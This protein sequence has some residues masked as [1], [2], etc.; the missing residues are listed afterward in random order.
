[1]RL[2]RLLPAG[3]ALVLLIAILVFDGGSAYAQDVG[4]S[5]QNAT[6]AAERSDV[7]AGLVDVAV[8]NRA[9]IEAQLTAT[10]TRISD[11]SAQLSTVAA[12]LDR[13]E[14]Q[15]VFADA[16]M[17]SI[18]AE[19]E[20]QA[21]EAY[22]NALAIP[23][24]SFVNSDTVESALVAG[25]VVEEV[26]VSGRR[27]VEHLVAKR[28]ELETLQADYLNKQDEVADLK[29]QVDLE[30][31]KLAALYDQADAKV[32][33]AIREANA[34][35]V[36]YRSALSAVDSARAR[37][38]EQKRQDERT[39]TTA[40]APSSPTPTTTSPP[41][42]SSP[43]TSGGGSGGSWTGKPGVE[44]WRGA[45]SQYFPAHRVDEALQ[46]MQCESLGDPNAYN[47]YSGASGLYQFLPAT[48][49][50]TAPM[51]GFPNVSV[52][53]PVANIATAAWLANRYEQLGQNYWQP[54]SCR[55][56]LN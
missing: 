42:T 9:E 50:T 21:V 40:T 32:A 43:T 35:D 41:P 44:Q 29:A 39:T 24:L 25:A 28:N 55:R 30:V 23:M 45:V 53:E 36:E 6:D 8:A 12:G 48:W 51:A 33:N 34:A 11:L 17:T 19:I 20:V 15:I 46:I 49:A 52:F 1:M 4:D 37:E 47:P 7:A 38:A 5:E 16:E 22:M 14:E 26:I 13:V 31:E 54:W 3:L 27:E 18:E 56:V 10:L 2:P